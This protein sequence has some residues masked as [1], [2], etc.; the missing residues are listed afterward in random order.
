MPI[1]KHKIKGNNVYEY[2]NG[3]V[4]VALAFSICY[5]KGKKAPQ[6]LHIYEKN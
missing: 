2:K 4:A 6:C 5:L 3:D 1:R